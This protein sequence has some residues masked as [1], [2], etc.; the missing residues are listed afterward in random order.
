MS[1]L[2]SDA[3]MVPSLVYIEDDPLCADLVREALIGRFTVRW[4]RDGLEGL[5]Q[6]ESAPPAL[7]LVDLQLPTLSGFDVI[8]QL[9][10]SP[11]H[12]GI[13]VIAISARVM[14]DE[15]AKAEAFGCCD[16]I[17][18]PFELATLRQKVADAAEKR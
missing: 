15:I 7:I 17:G 12:A 1:A 2:K 6:I 9:R 5:R 16:F 4:A 11:D 10:Q 14:H 8:E 3:H 13:P 18:K